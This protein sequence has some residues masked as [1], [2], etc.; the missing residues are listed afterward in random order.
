MYAKSV[1]LVSIATFFLMFI[2]WF[3]AKSQL[4]SVGDGGYMELL[5]LAAFLAAFL[6][7]AQTALGG[8]YFWAVAFAAIA[9]LFNPFAPLT[10]SRTT[11]LVLDAVSIWVFIVSLTL[12]WTEP[13]ND[14]AV[15]NRM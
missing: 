12:S 5:A 10:L 3:A 9:V 1:K 15:A 7:V 4:W 2:W 8:K 11:F 6:L 13:R 14:P